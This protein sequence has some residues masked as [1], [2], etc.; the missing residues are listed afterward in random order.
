[1]KKS[2]M[3]P[4]L[5]VSQGIAALAWSAL[6]LNLV[7]LGGYF[8]GQ[9]HPY[10]ELLSHFRGQ[11]L[12]VGWVGVALFLSLDFWWQRSRR[13]PTPS[14]ALGVSLSL[15]CL[16]INLAALVPW[17][18]P[19]AA[20]PAAGPVL[21]CL[22]ANVYGRNDQYDRLLDLIDRSQP[23]LIVLLEF[24]PDWQS[25]LQV[26]DRNFPHQ[27]P[28]PRRDSFGA[29][30]YSRLPLDQ[31]RV[32][33]LAQS[34]LPTIVADL[35]WND[36]PFRL[37]SIHPP[38]PITAPSFALRNALLKQW[39][40]D[41]QTRDRPVVLAGDWNLSPWS[42]YYHQFIK[43]TELH[44]SSQGFGL[45]ATWPTP[46][47]L[48]QKVLE[49]TG[50][51]DRS[52]GFAA[53]SPWPWG[54]SFWQIPIDHVLISPEWRS[55]GFQRGDPIGSDHYPLIVDLQWHPAFPRPR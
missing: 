40:T 24:T 4:K 44:N 45:Q 47:V 51:A 52:A 29:A 16:G 33:T 6:I 19:P 28:V 53:T 25:A 1:M 9:L 13:W 26:L 39:A 21:R 35:T 27:M 37:Y 36:H 54:E 48:P 5:Q 41:L 8:F 20:P 22:V 38:P 31:V 3:V 55:V 49:K 10:L 34:N 32:E 43:Q 50:K 30:L 17:Y 23:D 7:S 18:L 46:G 15:F 2:R 11:T 42:P 12:A 14:H